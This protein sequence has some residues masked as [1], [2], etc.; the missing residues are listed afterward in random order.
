ME[1]FFLNSIL[2]DVA[3]V[4]SIFSLIIFDYSYCNLSSC[5]KTHRRPFCISF[6]FNINLR[7]QDVLPSLSIVFSLNRHFCHSIFLLF[8]FFKNFYND[9]YNIL[10][11]FIAPSRSFFATF[12]NFV[13]G[14]LKRVTESLQPCRTISIY[15]FILYFF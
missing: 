4:T 13:T 8:F 3:G 12:Y 5:T 2:E 7:Q 15:K 1:L 9:L 14:L 6:Y 11:T 10:P